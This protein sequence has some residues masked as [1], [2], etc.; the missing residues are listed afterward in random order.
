M[1]DINLAEDR[2]RRMAGDVFSEDYQA[3]S[4]EFL[5]KKRE[6]R[7]KATS[8]AVKEGYRDNVEKERGKEWYDKAL[9]LGLDHATKGGAYTGGE[10]RAEMRYGRGDKTVDEMRE[11]YQGLID[12]GT[13]FNG[14]ARDFLAD[15]HGLIFPDSGGGE[16]KPGKPDDAPAQPVD[17]SPTPAPTPTPTPG[18]DNQEIGYTPPVLGYPGMEQIQNINQDNDITSNVTGDDNTVTNTQDNSIRQY[19]GSS[20]RFSTAE[21]AKALRDRY[22]ADVSRFAGVK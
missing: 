9:N 19:G 20:R 21:R 1:S 5:K 16:T 14:N 10:V 17:E 18:D 11:Y 2:K 6:I 7:T 22:V 3:P 4:E 12:D 13:K 8:Q 15:K